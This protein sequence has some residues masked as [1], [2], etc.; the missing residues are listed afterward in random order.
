MEALS[1]VSARPP[2]GKPAAQSFMPHPAF[3]FGRHAPGRCVLYLLRF[4]FS[5]AWILF[6]RP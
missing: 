1:F 3:S 2:A 5:M 6:G 4:W